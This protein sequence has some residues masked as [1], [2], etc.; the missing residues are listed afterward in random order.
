M[1]EK[2]LE[3]IVVNR[4][5]SKENYWVYKIGQKKKYDYQDIFE[6]KNIKNQNPEEKK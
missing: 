3:E 1:D 2:Q 4:G 6:Q 5:D